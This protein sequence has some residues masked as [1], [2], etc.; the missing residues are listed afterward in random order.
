MEKALPDTCTSNLIWKHSFDGIES[1]W[2]NRIECLQFSSRVACG[3]NPIVCLKLMRCF[4]RCTDGA[5]PPSA[6]PPPIAII[7]ANPPMPLDM[8]DE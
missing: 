5:L 8:L 2:I 1:M 3:N 4:H 7:S 6:V